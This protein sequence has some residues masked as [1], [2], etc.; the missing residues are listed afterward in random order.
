MVGDISPRVR[1]AA[2]RSLFSVFNAQALVAGHGHVLADSL[3][4]AAA[5]VGLFAL[6]VA[7]FQRRQLAL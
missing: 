5:T 6:A 1:W 2:H 4:L 7:G 3:W